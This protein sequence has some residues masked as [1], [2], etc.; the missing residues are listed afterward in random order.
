MKI[1]WLSFVKSNIEQNFD[2]FFGHKRTSVKAVNSFFFNTNI[3][4]KLW[5]PFTRAK[6]NE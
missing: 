3:T 1:K 4:N 6:S 2:F 5:I